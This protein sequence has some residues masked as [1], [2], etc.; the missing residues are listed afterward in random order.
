[1]FSRLAGGF[2]KELSPQVITTWHRYLL[3]DDVSDVK[4]LWK[5]IG[6]SSSVQ[7]PLA[8]DLEASKTIDDRIDRLRKEVSDILKSFKKSEESPGWAHAPSPEE[9]AYAHLMETEIINPWYGVQGEGPVGKRGKR[10]K[11]WKGR[12][13]IKDDFDELRRIRFAKSINFTLPYLLIAMRKGTWIPSE[14]KK[15]MI[16]DSAQELKA[17]ELGLPKMPASTFAE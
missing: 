17:L 14:E 4:H 16:F 13:P 1:V 11:G 15:S 7:D 6:F 12:P 10:K 5:V 8:R 2:L 9:V 3:E